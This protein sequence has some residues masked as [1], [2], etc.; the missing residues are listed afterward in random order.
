MGT[1]LFAEVGKRLKD[2]RESRGFTQEQ[3]E[4]Y[5]NINRVQLSYYETGKREIGMSTLIKLA[6]LYGYSTA[7]FLGDTETEMPAAISFR[8]E[9]I[10]EED[11]E[12]IALVHR[13]T[14]N[15]KYM[16]SL[17]VRD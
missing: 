2:A 4:K 11:F 15:L 14:K 9:G 12:T 16:N 13:F 17:L 7:Y 6:D 1:N 3:I 10:A 5:L 8:A